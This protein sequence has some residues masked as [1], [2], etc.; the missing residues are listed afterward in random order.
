MQDLLVVGVQLRKIA[1]YICTY[2]HADSHATP[3]DNMSK[4]SY[5]IGNTSV[6]LP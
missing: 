4:T 1:L 2:D 6:D 5:N 3:P